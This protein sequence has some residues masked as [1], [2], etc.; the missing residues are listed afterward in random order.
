LGCL[1]KDMEFLNPTALLG[2]LALPLLLVPYLIRRK[3]RRLVF[4]SLL[5]FI[6]A[7]VQASRPWG[8]IHLPPI[9]FLQLLLL[10]LLILALSEPVFSVR[11]T[12]IAIVLDNSA[13][14]Q[15]LED[16]KTRLSLAKESATSVIGELGA[17]GTVDLYVTT[18]RLSKVRAAPLDP[19]EAKAAVGAITGFDL[20]DPS[21]DYDNV[22]SQL[23]RER[24]YER[25]YLITDH[26]ARGQT[27]NARVI[28]IGR[29]QHN[30][31]VTGFEIHRAS[32]V[33]ARLE[34]SA[35]IVNFSDR[36]EKLKVV[37]KGSGTTLAS[38]ELTVGADKT[39]SVSFEGFAEQPSYEVAIAA[40]DD[41]LP[42][43]NHRFAVAPA[44]RR[45]Q[46]LAVTP[47]PQAMMSLKS[48]PGIT[49][50]VLPPGEYEKSERSGYGLEIFHFSAPAAPPQNPA[51]FILPPESHALAKPGAPVSNAAVSGWRE[52]HTLT[53]YINFSLF[54]PIYARPLK[55]QSAG[56]VV[57][58]SPNGALAFATERQGIRYLT[59][60]FDPLPFL[61]RENLPMSIFTLNFIDWFFESGGSS[62]QATGEPIRLGSVQPGD[63][64]TTPAGS[65]VS[66][67]PESGY[68]PATFY[69]GIYQRG[70]GG[71]SE[72]YARN[73]QDTNESDLRK[74]IPIE[75]R[76]TAP[77]STNASV[78]FSFWPYLLAASL[79]LL[80][81][82]WFVTPRMALFGFGRRLRRAV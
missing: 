50:D 59:L 21:V 30:L 7:G 68:F 9:F 27:A 73:L 43:D 1:N 71:K 45:L 37:L 15:A 39:A 46:I 74:P 14:M 16:G 23:A 13:S 49:V 32:L 72:F 33:N 64:L 11:P 77:N 78:L 42:L 65:Q 38:R 69:Q 58:E 26:P 60:G 62:G 79:L 41:A 52:P 76:G 34:A 18:P 81:I 2:L 75:L 40:R 3:P 22:L 51:L 67:R 80:L 20:G 24:K 29:P 47:R 12:N 70:R 48:I 61:G 5:L 6:E 44:S 28:T 66:L 55:P 31:A 25:V 54:R 63:V 82:E 19:V 4:S 35:K 17:G 10:A 57:I 8:R 53:R 56:D 36:D